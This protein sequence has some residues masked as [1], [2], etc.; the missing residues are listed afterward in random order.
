MVNPQLC[1]NG[2]CSNGHSVAGAVNGNENRFRELCSVGLAF[3]V[4]HAIVK[5]GRESNL[6]GA[7]EIDLRNYL[8]LVALGTIADIVP[9]TG[10]NRILAAAGLDRLRKTA[11]PGLQALKSVAQT[12]GKLGTHEVGFQLAPRLNAAGRLETASAALDLL[13]AP[14][15][16]AA[17]ELARKLDGHNRDRQKIEKEIVLEAIE[18]IQNRLNAASSFVIV[19]GRPAWHIGVVGIVASRVLQQFYRPT[20]IVGG[21]GD[22]WRGSGRSIAGFDLAA[23]LRECSDLLI[24]HGGHSMAA[25]V[26]LPAH[27]LDAFRERIEGIGRRLLKNEHLQ[28]RVR[29]DAGI[30]LPDINLSS[31][32]ALDR[33]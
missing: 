21:D 31:I 11:R 25:G 32:R 29:L 20:I 8:D 33:P 26:T 22:E 16:A 14:D 18:L 3:K 6:P 15:F 13:L 7:H 4:A 9:L 12:N 23:A 5:R 24:R 17:M 28:P 27:N 30:G 1:G 2:S 19:E 10:E